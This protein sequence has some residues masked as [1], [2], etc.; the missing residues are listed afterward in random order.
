VFFLSLRSNHAPTPEA[1]APKPNPA[2]CHPLQRME[3]TSERPKNSEVCPFPSKQEYREI[4]ARMHIIYAR[5]RH[6]FMYPWPM[7][8]LTGRFH[9]QVCPSRQARALVVLIIAAATDLPKSDTPP[10]ATEA[11]GAQLVIP[12]P[13]CSGLVARHRRLRQ[14]V[15]V[16][17]PSLRWAMVPHDGGFDGR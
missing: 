12:P 16:A 14:C 15:A 13:C 5:S 10:R 7:Y 1:Y 3:A 2:V 8:G 17:Q 4:E 11:A 6:D 9:M